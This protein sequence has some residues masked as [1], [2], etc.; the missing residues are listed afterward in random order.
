MAKWLRVLATLRE[1]QSCLSALTTN[2]LLITTYN[3]SSRDS[4]GI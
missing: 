2:G 4:N 1:D 3:S